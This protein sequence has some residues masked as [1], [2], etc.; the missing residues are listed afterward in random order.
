MPEEGAQ[1]IRAPLGAPLT[2]LPLLEKESYGPVPTSQGQ[3]IPGSSLDTVPSTPPAS[4][5]DD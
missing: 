2:A 4:S 1:F 3:P 5:A